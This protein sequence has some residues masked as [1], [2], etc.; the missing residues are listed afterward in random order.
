MSDTTIS[1]RA[2]HVTLIN[3]FTVS[4]ENQERLVRMLVEATERVHGA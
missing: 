2:S 3:V 4:V 1:T